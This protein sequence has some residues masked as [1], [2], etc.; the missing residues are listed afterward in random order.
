MT[1]IKVHLIFDSEAEAVYNAIQTMAE[2][3]DWDNNLD[4]ATE[5]AGNSK[6]DNPDVIFINGTVRVSLID[7]ATGKKVSRANAIVKRLRKI[8]LNKPNS[9]IIVILP[10]DQKEEVRFI[11]N[12]ISLGIYDVY[13]VSEFNEEIMRQ[14]FETSK[15]IADV[16]QYLPGEEDSLVTEEETEGKI[17][18]EYPDEVSDSDRGQKEKLWSFVMELKD[19]ALKTIER[20]SNKGVNNSSQ[21]KVEIYHESQDNSVQVTSPHENQ[22]KYAHIDDAACFPTIYS[23]CVCVPDDDNTATWEDAVNFTAWEQ[24][25]TAIETAP[26]DL[27]L[28]DGGTDGLED[29]IKYLRR[30]ES[31]GK[32]PIGVMGETEETVAYRAGADECF[33]KWNDK[34]AEKLKQ[35]RARLN[36]V[37]NNA[38]R[39]ANRDALTGLYNRGFLAGYLK[40]IEIDFRKNEVPFSLMIC[41]L[42]YF[43]NINDTHG[44]QVGDEVL[45]KFAEYLHKYTKTTDIVTRYGGEEFVVVFPRTAKEV[46]IEV[47]RQLRKGWQN[48]QVYKTTFSGGVAEY[49]KDGESIE[50]VI[51]AADQALYNAKNGGRNSVYLAGEQRKE[52]VFK[53]EPVKELQTRVFIVVGAAPRVGATSFSLVLAKILSKKY[54]VEILDAGGGAAKWLNRDSEINVRNANTFSISPGIVTVVDAGLKVPEEIVGLTDAIFIITD[55]SRSAVKLKEYQCYNPYLIGNRGAPLDALKELASLWEMEALFCMPESPEIREA[56]IEGK[57]KVPKSWNKLLKKIL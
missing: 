5:W 7:P 20:A 49:P 45:Q 36:A 23:L 24:L 37:W 11:R 22:D 14:W 27:I 41:D 50:Q 43:K 54:D 25:V 21:D 46:A 3:T 1:T 15:S 6:K 9:K 55:L 26:P 40:E 48:Q 8:R 39:E 32:V 35:K 33:H 13:F 38:S 19:K 47:A 31:L 44:H 57:I 4:T 42:D 56:E 51:K 34:V 10:E 16:Q 53:V 2:V 52:A 30:K 17:A 18:Y 28:L 12:L 29:K